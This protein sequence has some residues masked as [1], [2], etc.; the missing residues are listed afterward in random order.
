MSK[1]KPKYRLICVMCGKPF[2]SARQNTRYCSDC[3]TQPHRPVNRLD[4]TKSQLRNCPYC[5][6]G[7]KLTALMIADVPRC[8]YECSNDECIASVLPARDFA[9]KEAAAAAWNSRL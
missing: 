3:R 8:R 4:P 9:T 7:P 5:G 2:D 6:S 1:H